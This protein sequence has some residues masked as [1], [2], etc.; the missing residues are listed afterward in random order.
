MINADVKLNLSSIYS[1]F[2]VPELFNY[3]AKNSQEDIFYEDDIWPGESE[4]G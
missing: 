2:R 3:I 4:N 1:F